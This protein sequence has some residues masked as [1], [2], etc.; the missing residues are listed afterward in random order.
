MVVGVFLGMKPSAGF[1]VRIT[2]VTAKGTSAVVEYVEGRP[3]PGMMTAQVITFPFHLV[4]LPR[5]FETVEFKK[6]DK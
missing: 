4:S 5:T 6:I 1:S 3:K 2:S